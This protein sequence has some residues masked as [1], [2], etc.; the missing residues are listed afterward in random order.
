MPLVAVVVQPPAAA[1]GIDL[2]LRDVYLLA[3]ARA[4]LGPCVG[5]FG[6][7]RRERNAGQ[8]SGAVAK[9]LAAGLANLGRFTGGE[10][11]GDG[12]LAVEKNSGG[13]DGDVVHGGCE[14]MQRGV[15]RGDDWQVRDMKETEDESLRGS[16][17]S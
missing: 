9:R 4:S 14:S 10:W 13:E 11:D 17:G 3:G 7:V 6:A 12:G 16:Y 8:A 2:L 15:E 1:E 5:P